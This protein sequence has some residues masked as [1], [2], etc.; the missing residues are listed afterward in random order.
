MQKIA[1]FGAGGLGREL[2]VLIEDINQQKPTYEFVGFY[3][4]GIA[5]G[6]V[7]NGFPVLGNLDD[8]N[9]IQE[10]ICLVIAIG[11]SKG[12]MSIFEKINNPH[13]SYPTLIHPSVLV[14]NDD[15]SIGKGTIICSG[16]IITCNIK[17]GNFVLVGSSCTLCHDTV[18]QDFCSLMLGINI[19]GEVKVKKGV[20]IGTGAKIINQVEIGENA[21]IGLGA[22]VIRD[23][24]S[25][26]IVAGNPA[27]VI[28]KNC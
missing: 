21:T 23:V 8:L 7:V 25:F 12:R 11:T 22:V 18:I 1:I 28:S 3:D 10:D 24:A 17:I 4:D 19:S 9:Q 5:Q 15:V 27:K 20:Y 13:I 2:K 26:T 14:S 6:T 16:V